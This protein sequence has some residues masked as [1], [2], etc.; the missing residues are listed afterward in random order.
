MKAP[1]MTTR[2]DYDAIV[3]GARCAGAAPAMLLALRG[4]RVLAIDR[5]AYGTDT[6][7]THA[8]MRGAVAQLARWGLLDGV[9]A[10]GTPDY[11][12][13]DLARYRGSVIAADAIRSKVAELVGADTPVAGKSATSV[14]FGYFP[15]LANE[16]YRFMYHPGL[17]AGVIPT[18]EGQSCVFLGFPPEKGGPRIDAEK[19]FRQ[20]L[21]RIS[22]WLAEAISRTEPPGEWGWTRRVSR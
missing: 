19:R 22:P 1:V 7:S 5:G 12:E 11:F 13:K 3:V 21:A 8:L 18:N 10:A 17:T 2:K 15:G 14:I 9:K 4:L 20:G 6:L 16:G